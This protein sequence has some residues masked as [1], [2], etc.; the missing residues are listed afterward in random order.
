MPVK[1]IILIAGSV[2]ITGFILS[3]FMTNFWLFILFYGCIGALGC[4][5]CYMTALVVSW[6]HFPERK[7]LI[8]GVIDGGYGLGSLAYTQ[9]A[10]AIVNPDNLDA[11]IPS[12]QENLTYFDE[13]VAKNVPMMLRVLA[14]IW[15]VQITFAVLLIERKE[16]Q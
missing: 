15:A 14:L 2:S 16:H 5:I 11:T 3:S 4:G 9:I 7:G 10:R 1:F 12:G 6:E 8:T 13:R